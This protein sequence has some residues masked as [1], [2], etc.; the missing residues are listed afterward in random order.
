MEN[1]VFIIILPIFQKKFDKLTLIFSAICQ[2]YIEY[3]LT[4]IFLEKF[5][6]YLGC[7]ITNDSINFV[8]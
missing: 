2:I 6:F 3:I 7:F 4:L 1:Y 8:V 5:K